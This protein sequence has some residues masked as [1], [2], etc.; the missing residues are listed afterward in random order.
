MRTNVFDK[1]LT[2]H[3]RND[4]FDVSDSDEDDSIEI[5]HD[6][7]D[8]DDSDENDSLPWP[9]ISGDDDTPVTAAAWRDA[10]TSSTKQSTSRPL[11]RSEG[12]A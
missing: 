7:D 11:D 3:L 6:N 12:S 1:R 4:I 5:I 10:I 8:S 9:G 2:E